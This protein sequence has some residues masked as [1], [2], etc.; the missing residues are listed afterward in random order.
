VIK[1]GKGVC[2][3]FDPKSNQ[4]VSYSQKHVVKSLKR[5]KPWWD[6]ECQ[7][8]VLDI[9]TIENFLKTRVTY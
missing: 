2:K 1:D 7:V 4:F 5:L 3:R 9:N 8:V 6:S